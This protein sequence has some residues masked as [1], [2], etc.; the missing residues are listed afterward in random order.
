[1][2]DDTG[3]TN[4][5]LCEIGITYTPKK[6]KVSELPKAVVSSDCVA[7]LREAFPDLGYRE[8]FYIV[9]LNNNNRILGY[10]QISKGG[11]SGTVVDVR[12]IMQTALK[13]NASCIILAHNHPSGNLMPSEADKEMTRKIKQAGTYLD[14]KV[15]DHVILT[16]ESYFSFADEGLI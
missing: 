10:T 16:P 11:I 5:V 4:F 15:L 1:M 13:S 6:F 9:C 14:I 2:K 12:I 8:Y 7:Y 3:V